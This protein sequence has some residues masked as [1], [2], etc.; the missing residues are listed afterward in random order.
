MFAEAEGLED[1]TKT[2]VPFRVWVSRVVGL[3]LKIQGLGL[4]IGA[5]GL[6][7][8][9]F[10]KLLTSSIPP[11]L[12]LL[13]HKKCNVSLPPPPPQLSSSQHCKW[14]A[15]TLILCCWALQGYSAL[16]H[17]R[18][19][20]RLGPA[21]IFGGWTLQGYSAVGHCRDTLQLG[22]AGILCGWALQG[23]LVVEHCR[24]TLRLGSVRILCGSALVGHC[25]DT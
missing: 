6:G 16:G 3:G 20:F 14:A 8:R 10:E 17:C 19:T 18:N 23:Y 22:T 11:T 9:S 5:S 12:K 7:L 4:R 13:L 2:L 21:G 25:K 1:S 15:R 24:D